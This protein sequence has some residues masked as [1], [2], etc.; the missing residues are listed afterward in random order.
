MI[1]NRITP[2][3]YAALKKAYGRHASWA[4]WG[5]GGDVYNPAVIEQAL[6]R[7]HAGYVFVGL[8][9]SQ[10]LKG[11][12]PWTNYHHRHQGSREKIFAPVFGA[13]PTGGAYM[14]DIV[15]D[16]PFSSTAE[17]LEYLKEDT[18]AL[19]RNIKTLVKELA[20]LGPVGKII[21]IGGAAKT[22]WESRCRELG[23]PACAIT[24]FS[25]RGSAFPDNA[26]GELRKIAACPCAGR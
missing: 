15:K 24:H 5:E 23:H 6:P 19:D 13:P 9:A 10:D 4:V 22:I 11:L 26:P 20:A 1:K 12:A 3:R 16:C 8:N 2:E 25:A 17:V 18:A 21:L 14:T 7:L